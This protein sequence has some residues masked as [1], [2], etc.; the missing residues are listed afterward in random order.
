MR[1]ILRFFLA[2]FDDRFLYGSFDIEVAQPGLLSSGIPYDTFFSVI[3]QNSL[4][5]FACLGI[6][7]CAGVYWYVAFSTVL[8]GYGADRHISASGDKHFIADACIFGDRV[9]RVFF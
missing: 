5:L 3:F 9:F 6:D 4:K 7:I 2:V 1:H 8:I